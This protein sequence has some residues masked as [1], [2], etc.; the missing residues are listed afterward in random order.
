MRISDWS[1]DVCSSDLQPWVERVAVRARCR[2]AFVQRRVEHQRV[3]G[4]R[5]AVVLARHVVEDVA[6]VGATRTTEDHVLLVA[7]QVIGE[8]APGLPCTLEVVAVASGADVVLDVVKIGTASCR[9]RVCQYVYV[10]VVAVSLKK[11]K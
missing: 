1:S 4:K 11:K 10:S 9:E 2:V 8:A 5:T 6:V 7:E 3:R